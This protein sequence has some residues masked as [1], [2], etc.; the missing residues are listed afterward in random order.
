MGPDYTDFCADMIIS[1]R[2]VAGPGQ[3]VDDV[4]I[5]YA[6]GVDD[7][8]KLTNF[9]GGLVARGYNDDE[10]RGILGENFLRVFKEVYEVSKPHL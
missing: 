4:D 9:T 6:D 3:P 1:S 10:I 5:P 8:T 7:M 2:R